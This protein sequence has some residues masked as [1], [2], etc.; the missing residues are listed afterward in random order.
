MEENKQKTDFITVFA[1]RI[2]NKEGADYTADALA[3]AKIDQAV[4]N[5]W[6]LTDQTFAQIYYDL[7]SP[8]ANIITLQNYMEYVQGLRHKLLSRSDM[9]NVDLEK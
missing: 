4:L 9:I 7:Q 2:I 6:I 1:T 3:F 8:H 5:Q